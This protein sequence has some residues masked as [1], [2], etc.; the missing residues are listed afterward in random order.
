MQVNVGGCK[1]CWGGGGARMKLGGGVRTLERR[2]KGKNK[3]AVGSSKSL[4]S[5][6]KTILPTHLEEKLKDHILLME[7]CFFG[8]TYTDVRKLAYEL[9]VKNNLPNT[10]KGGIAGYH[11][12]YAF[13]RRYPELSLRKPESKSLARSRSFNKTNVDN[14]FKL[15]T[16][17]VAKHSFTPK[18]AF[19]YDVRFRGGEGVWKI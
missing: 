8:L 14:F 2:A 1:T 5:A 13:L 19:T 12:L 6:G 16:N 15:Y 10:F 4:G 17:M 7:E 9:A 18:G 3:L 11:W